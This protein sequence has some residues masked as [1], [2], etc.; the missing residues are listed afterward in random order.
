MTMNKPALPDPT[1]DGVDH[2]RID[3]NA[4]SRLGRK[5]P[6]LAD[7]RV[8]HPKHGIFRTAQGLWEYLKVEKDLEELKAATGFEA[9][10][11]S[12][13]HTP[14]WSKRFKEDVKTAMVSKIEDNIEIYV[15]FAESSLPFRYYHMQRNRKIIEPKETLWLTEWLEEYRAE[16]KA[17]I[18]KV[19]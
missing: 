1:L 13:R 17:R 15:A 6:L 8:T 10:K 2:I 19:K 9:K 7:V 16:V 18:S 14:K 12:S 3:L 5:L 11:I 4:T